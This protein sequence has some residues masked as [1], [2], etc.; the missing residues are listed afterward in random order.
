MTTPP[1][2]APSTPLPV[3]LARKIYH[4]HLRAA[5]N[6]YPPAF[7]KE[8]PTAD[9]LFGGL[10]T[11]TLDQLAGALVLWAVAGTHG[12]RDARERGGK[13]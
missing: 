2:L 9:A 11:V 3:T 8:I 7:L 10:K 6:G 4:A 5:S 12:E 1:T 13:E